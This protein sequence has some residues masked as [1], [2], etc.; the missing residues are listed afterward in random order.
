MF[1]TF[2]LYIVFSELKTKWISMFRISF[3][4]LEFFFF[5]VFWTTMLLDT[6]AEKEIV[7]VVTVPWWR[8]HM[9]KCLVCNLNNIMH[10]YKCNAGKTQKQYI[11][12]QREG[13]DMKT[14]SIMAVT[15]LEK[16]WNW[17]LNKVQAWIFLTNFTTAQVVCVTA[18]INHV[19][20]SF[21]SSSN[22][23][24]HIFTFKEQSIA[25]LEVGE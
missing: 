14:W 5:R 17:S 19:F 21:S 1:Y 23:W 3:F 20:I 9:M 25:R 16:L 18:I 10:R 24:Y 12:H 6:L 11:S 15:Q 8:N 4:N 2:I 7:V 13:R 22:I